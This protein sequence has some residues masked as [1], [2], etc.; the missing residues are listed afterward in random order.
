M[1]DPSAVCDL[2]IPDLPDNVPVFECWEKAANRIMQNLSKQN[3][4]HI[5]AERVDPVALNIPDYFEIVKRPMDFGLIR[6]KLK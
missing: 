6:S 4:A 1:R 3:G 2:K 5:F